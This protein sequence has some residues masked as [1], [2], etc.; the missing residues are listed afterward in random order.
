MCVNKQESRI[1][2][3]A[4]LLAYINSVAAFSTVSEVARTGIRYTTR[5]CLP[6]SSIG[7]IASSI[8]M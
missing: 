1:Y 4:I 6:D 7:I 5:P 8:R 2:E 3:P